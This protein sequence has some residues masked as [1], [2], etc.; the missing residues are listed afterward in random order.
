MESLIEKIENLLKSIGDSELKKNPEASA[1]ALEIKTL[2]EE[3]KQTSN[4]KIVHSKNKG[5]LSYLAPKIL[6][7]K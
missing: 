4:N 7:E 1:K 6:L 3:L 2:V 5:L